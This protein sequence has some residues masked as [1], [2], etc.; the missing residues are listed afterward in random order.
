[1]FARLLLVS[2]ILAMNVGGSMFSLAAENR[3]P[4]VLILGD[5]VSYYNSVVV[6]K[7]LKD[8]AVV[9]F[10]NGTWGDTRKAL[11]KLQECLLADGGNWSV[12]HFNWG[13]HDIKN[14][15]TVPIKEYEENLRELVKFLKATNARLV[16]ASIT[17]VGL[18]TGNAGDRLDSNVVAYNAVAKKIMDENKIQIDDLY[19]AA[20]PRIADIQKA[21]GVHFN[22]EGCQ[23]LSTFIVKAIQTALNGEKTSPKK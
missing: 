6:T 18:K 21:D 12:I 3:Q 19:A 5:S 2:F 22:D 16:W 8:Q 14:R 10:N 4:R 15:I 7:S 9:V 23:F 1:M 17:P 20:K 13:L 11:A